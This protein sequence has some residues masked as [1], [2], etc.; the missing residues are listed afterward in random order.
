LDAIRTILRKLRAD[1]RG[2]TAIEYGLICALI[3]VAMMGGLQAMGGGS[4][5]M[6]GK[7]L[8]NVNA[9]M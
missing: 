6:W 3:I 4:Q 1:E 2:A 8:A 5:G 7:I 9:Y